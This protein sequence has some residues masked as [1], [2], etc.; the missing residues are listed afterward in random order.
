MRGSAVPCVGPLWITWADNELRRHAPCT[1]Q[2]TVARRR[3]RGQRK[4]KTEGSGLSMIVRRSK[5][6]SPRPSPGVPGEGAALRERVESRA[7]DQETKKRSLNLG[8]VLCWAL[9]IGH[10]AGLGTPM[11]PSRGRL[12]KWGLSTLIAWPKNVRKRKKRKVDRRFQGVALGRGLR[13]F[14]R[15]VCSSKSV[16]RRRRPR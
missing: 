11:D 12:E 10:C 14:S 5:S 8:L 16:R 3:M 4:R 15:K 1:G 2:K 13:F 9:V 6:P 7:V